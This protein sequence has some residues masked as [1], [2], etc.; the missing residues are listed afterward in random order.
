MISGKPPRPTQDK[1][2]PSFARYLEP[3]WFLN[4]GD[5][6]VVAFA[7]GATDGVQTD[8]E[9]AARL[10]YAVRDGIWYS[11]Y[12]ITVDREAYRASVILAAEAAFCVQKAIVLAAAARVVG[13]PSRLGYADVRNHLASEKLL[14]SLRTDLFV[15]HGYTE[16]YLDGRWLKATPTFNQ[17]LC[18]RFRVKPLEFDGTADAILHPYDEE[19]RR[20]MEYV[21]DRGSF[22]DFPFEEMLR[23]FFETYS[24]MATEWHGGP[25]DDPEFEPEG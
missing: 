18:K 12:V 22:A 4:S 11:P 9:R 23:V 3:T 16:L 6:A 19:N 1:Y 25:V 14:S 7:S 21:R 15:F 10:Y 8:A 24:H 20:H 2:D 17:E 5:P 13:I